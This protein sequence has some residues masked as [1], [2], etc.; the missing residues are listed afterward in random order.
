MYIVFVE[1]PRQ[2]FEN[3]LHAIQIVRIK[4]YDIAAT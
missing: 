1:L 2:K 3:P 4:K